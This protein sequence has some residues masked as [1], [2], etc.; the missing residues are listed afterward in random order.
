MFWTSCYKYVWLTKMGEFSFQENDLAKKRP[1]C[2]WHALFYFNP[3]CKQ[4]KS[5][6]YK[7]LIFQNYCNFTFGQIRS[8]HLTN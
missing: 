8:F 7:F 2:Q 4:W 3:N 6:K 1:C 5:K